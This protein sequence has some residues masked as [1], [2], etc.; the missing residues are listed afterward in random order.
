MR[1]VW[2]GVE[3]RGYAGPFPAHKATGTRELAV[4]HTMR[5]NT[6]KQA[7]RAPLVDKGAV[8]RRMHARLAHGQ[9]AAV[10]QRAGLNKA[11]LSRELSPSAPARITTDTLLAY[12]AETGDTVPLD[13]LLAGIGLGVHPL[14]A[15]ADGER[16]VL[17]V[18]GHVGRIASLWKKFTGADSA[19]GAAI[20]DEERN[21]LLPP[22]R[23]A[24]GDLETL[25]RGL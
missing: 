23:A 20:V 24:Q 22:I 18:M 1:P 21:A 15:P 25:A 12:T 8:V 17:G 7:A 9:H 11:Q 16:Q 4:R 5:T 19:G 3:S 14:P 13:A 6:A 2:R 10:A